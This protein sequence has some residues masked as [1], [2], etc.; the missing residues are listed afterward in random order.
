MGH[1]LGKMVKIFFS[2]LLILSFDVLSKNTSLSKHIEFSGDEL[3]LDKE[4]N[5]YTISAGINGITLKNVKIDKPSS[6]SLKMFK[7]ITPRDKFGLKLLDKDGSDIFL[8]GIGNPFYAHA[9]H[10]GYEDS[11]V[12]GGYITTDMDIAIPIN[13]DISHIVLVS[14]DEFG[15]KEIKK[16]KIN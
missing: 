11:N 3:S 10:I 9:Q 14:Q 12:F 1:K 5:I 8:M 13:V 16:I 2:F 7:L 4:A 6:N 15:L